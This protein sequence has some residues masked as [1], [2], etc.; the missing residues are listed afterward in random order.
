HPLSVKFIWVP[1][2]TLFKSTNAKLSGD[3]SAL[4]HIIAISPA[5]NVVCAFNSPILINKKKSVERAIVLS[6]CFTFISFV[7]KLVKK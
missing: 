6:K 5:D 2:S 1:A 3:P 7:L 4:Y